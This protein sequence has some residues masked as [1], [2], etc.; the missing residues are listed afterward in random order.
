MVPLIETIASYLPRLIVQRFATAPTTMDEGGKSGAAAES[1][2]AA[3]LFADISG[4]TGLAEQLARR[5][6]QGAEELTRLVNAYFGALI[7]L[8]ISY[9]GDIVKFA[10]DGL[11][12]LWPL[13]AE[14]LAAVTCRAAVCGLAIQ[15]QLQHTMITADVRLTLRVAIGAGTVTAVRL[16][17]VYGRWEFLVT[18]D[19]LVQVR[20]AEQQS[21]PGDVVLSPQAWALVQ[22]I[23]SAVALEA[24]AELPAPCVRLETIHTPLPL[25]T[26][27]APPLPPAIEPTLRGFL[28]GAILTRLIAGQS[29]WLAELRRVTVL[30]IKLP[31]LNYT[32]ALDTAQSAMCTLQQALYRYEGSINKLSVDDK[33]ITL[34]AAF[35]LPPLAHEDDPARG[36]Q[37]AL[38]IQARLHDLGLRSAIGVTTGRA[39]CGVVGNEQ[40]REYTMIGAVVNLAAR[41]M[42]AAANT[43]SDD[44]API[45]CDGPTYQA[46][47]QQ[48]TFEP[49]P[50]VMVKG[51]SEPVPI[52]RPIG[53]AATPIRPP[54]ALVGRVRERMVIIEQL[55][56]LLRSGT[57][58][59]GPAT[60]LLIEGEPG[61]G[62]SRLLEDLL[63]S[64]QSMGC[65]YLLGSGHAV[66]K[67]T[68]Y[69]AWRAVFNTLFALDAAATPEMRRAAVMAQIQADPD[70]LRLIPL[71]N[72]VLSLDLPDNPTTA[73]LAGAARA[74]QTHNLLVHLL[75]HYAQTTSTAPLV[76]A[77][78]D[79]HWL[80]SASWSLLGAVS[81]NLGEALLVLATRPLTDPLP[82]E[83]SHLL[84]SPRTTYLKLDAM[85]PDETL[86]LVSQRLGVAQL[87]EPMAALIQEKAEGNPF[88][89]EELAYALRD[90]GLITVVD[91]ICQIAPGVGDLRALSF[92][93]T[94]QGVITSR[95][96]RLTPAQ[97]LTL[98]TASVIGR[99]FGVRVLHAIHPMEDD[100]WKLGD[101]LSA[102]E[103]LNLTA[104]DSSEPEMAYL[105][106]H[107]IIQ[108]V[109]YNLMLFA[110]R[111]ELHRAVA[112]W[113]E[114]TYSSDLAPHYPILVHHWSRAEVPDRTADY[115][116]RA[117]DAAARLFAHTEARLH[118]AQALEALALLP[119]SAS[120]R[121][122]QIDTMIKQV[123]VAIAADG[124]ERSLE[125]LNEAERLLRRLAEEGTYTHADQ[126]R[127][128][129]IDYWKGRAHQV[130]NE[131]REAVGYFRRVL[132]VAHDLGDAEMLAIPASVLGRAMVSQGH[133]RQAIPLLRQ[134]VTPLEQ[135]GHS[136]DWVLTVG[137]L[138]IALTALGD[139]YAGVRE[140]ERALARAIETNNRSAIAVTYIHLAVLHSTGSAYQQS[141]E[142][143]NTAIAIAEQ[144]GDRLYA[145]LGYGYRAIAC[146]RMGDYAAASADLEQSQAI[147]ASLGGRLIAAD[148]FTI[149]AAEVA[150]HRGQPKLA[151]QLTEQGLAG[152]QIS[153]SALSAGYG[154]R[155]R[156]QALATLDPPQWDEAIAQM[157]ASLQVFNRS[158]SPLD[159]ARTYVAWGNLCLAQGDNA[160]AQEHFAEAALRFRAAGL[161]VE[162]TKVQHLMQGILAH[163]GFTH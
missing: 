6:P 145:Y 40:R 150:L 97:Q 103:Q 163:D 77:L 2:S 64:A 118:Y 85:P 79:A 149:V 17:G 54:T 75:Q 14:D 82:P 81:R 57:S 143:S 136:L 59:S 52:Y 161:E 84:Q 102:L 80:D 23:A 72:A 21:R 133:Y 92:P 48:L 93:D 110:Q 138:G 50:P 131:L 28:P 129:R 62:K 152:A 9:G 44:T 8:I 101:Y 78:E 19:P 15:T 61:I 117:A 18:G 24:N 100:R 158:D 73:S 22:P 38:E 45:F 55:Q 86:A 58:H 144:S 68:P 111:R 137:Y 11:I 3:V 88:F 30:F 132:A 99:V 121:R 37:A 66:E 134:A 120:N 20:I 105:F 56:G 128:A 123:G 155:I 125:R 124:P 94:V 114:Q 139:Y 147:S 146:C 31:D 46:A 126:V 157:Q 112:E 49:L 130:R 69:Y 104:L 76:L 160:A 148:I 151:L 70:A 65:P 7:D 122:R 41:L 63:Q 13:N 10:G 156:G 115:A 159:V 67:A 71:L 53:V 135:L 43:A 127:E 87:P 83:Y 109:A 96:D 119:D 47:Q 33:G 107:I 16:G 162:L 142:A 116:L 91:G 42:Q 39:F 106:K 26:A 29:G 113:Y 89:S 36:A 12:A 60:V 108:E 141:W 1:F 90:T 5:G 27:V 4:F 140:G 154:H 98:K 51:K 74:E 34:V 35:G 25:S 95:I 153:G 32:S